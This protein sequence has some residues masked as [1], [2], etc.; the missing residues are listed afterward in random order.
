[1]VGKQF[2]AHN[3]HINLYVFTLFNFTY[4][5]KK[6]I[7]IKLA[8]DHKNFTIHWV[9]VGGTIDWILMG[10]KSFRKMR[11]PKSKIGI[12]IGVENCFR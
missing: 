2:H 1:M 12:P 11:I 3:A 5:A 8:T 7:K 6:C 10:I 9:G 4:F